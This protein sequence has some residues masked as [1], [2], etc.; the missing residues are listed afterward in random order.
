[1]QSAGHKLSVFFS[2]YIEDVIFIRLPLEIAAKTSFSSSIAFDGERRQEN[3]TYNWTTSP[4]FSSFFNG[5][6]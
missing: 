3:K 5:N 4:T 2:F 1:M 6:F